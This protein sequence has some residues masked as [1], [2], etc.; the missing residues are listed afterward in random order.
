MSN[1]LHDLITRLR[2]HV[3]AS[4]EDASD[5]LDK[6]Y[7]TLTKDITD[8]IP[9]L[10][11]RARVLTMLNPELSKQFSEALVFSQY[12]P[13]IKPLQDAQPQQNG[14]H[15]NKLRQE[16]S[17]AQQRS[18]AQQ[19]NQAQQG[20]HT[21][22]QRNSGVQEVKTSVYYDLDE[23]DIIGLAEYVVKAFPGAIKLSEHTTLSLPCVILTFIIVNDRIDMRK[24][25]PICEYRQTQSGNHHFVV[26]V[27]NDALNNSHL[28]SE[29]LDACEV[30]SAKFRVQYDLSGMGGLS[31]QIFIPSSAT[32][33]FSKMTAFIQNC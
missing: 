20:L 19:T 5:T 2:E 11:K 17:Q 30:L 16:N 31:K 7:D 24:W 4:N 3:L 26:L 15:Q 10:Q 27:F 23:R 18:Q 29:K 22:Q 9:V 28:S 12:L 21:A 25:A 13:K 14:S 1:F 32:N 8:F 6:I 33:S